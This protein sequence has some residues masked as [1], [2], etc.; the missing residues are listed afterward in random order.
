MV[1]VYSNSY[2]KKVMNL[3]G[4]LSGGVCRTFTLRFRVA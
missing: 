4:R 3:V 2:K 1:R